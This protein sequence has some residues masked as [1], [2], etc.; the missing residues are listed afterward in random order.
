MALPLSLCAAESASSSSSLASI[1]PCAPYN[2][3][4]TGAR[5]R[6]ED[7]GA[8]LHARTEYT[9]RLGDIRKLRR[10]HLALN[11]GSVDHI[12]HRVIKPRQHDQFHQLVRCKVRRHPLP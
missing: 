6:T 2:V 11:T 5:L 7:Q 10:E 3:E 1:S 9:A 4:V 12:R 8:M